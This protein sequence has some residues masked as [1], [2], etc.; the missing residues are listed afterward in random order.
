MK[1]LGISMIVLTMFWSCSNSKNEFDTSGIFE[2]DEV[3]VSA[4]TTGKLLKMNAKEGDELKKGEIVGL[5]DDANL[6]LQKSQLEAS[7]EALYQKRNDA[8]PQVAIIR[9]QINNQQQNVL[10]LKQQLSIA[11]TEQNRVSNLV[12]NE[13]VPSKQLDDVN[14]QVAIL[15]QQIVAAESQ[16]QTLN[17]QI[18]SQQQN[19]A[20][21]N[22]SILSEKK[23]LEQR[24]AQ[25]D[26]QIRRAVVTNPIDGTVLTKY[27]TQDEMAVIGKPI[28]RIAPTKT[29]ILRAYI[30][31]SQ[32]DKLKLKQQV[33]V[34]TGT[35]D[36][37][38]ETTGT[39]TWISSKAEF[40][41]KTIQT[42]DERANLV[43]ATKI[44]VPNDG[45]LKIGMY[46]DVKF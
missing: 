31:G 28:Y 19:I 32:L 8:N 30:T 39:I 35:E 13:A 41:P 2:A 9:E 11:Q 27:L 33:K 4:E 21:Q 40:T 43:Y 7:I 5:I 15:K 23:P 3:I 1:N 46:A 22:R 34:F 17:Q 12:K 16:V 36:K 37:L 29:L 20:I 42:V 26:D 45:Y 14:G 24:V 44:A 25:L 38:K 18:K 6:K 10:T